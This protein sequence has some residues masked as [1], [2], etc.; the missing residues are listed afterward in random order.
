[1]RLQRFANSEMTNPMG[2]Q[3]TTEFDSLRMTQ[4]R[5]QQGN[6]KFARARDI[7]KYNGLG[8]REQ[9]KQMAATQPEGTKGNQF[10]EVRLNLEDSVINRDEFNAK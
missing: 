9:Q 1:M 7:H 3:K 2:P 5:S 4:A 6:R 8:S 10:E